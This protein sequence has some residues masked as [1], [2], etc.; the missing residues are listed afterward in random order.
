MKLFFLGLFLG[1]LLTSVL[2]WPWVTKLTIHYGDSGDYPLVGWMLWYNQHSIK[3]GDIFNQQN[4]FNSNQFYPFPYSLA[5][6]EHLFI[7]SLIFSPIFWLTKHFVFSVNFFAFLTFVLSFITSFYASYYFVKDKLAAFLG[8]A[9]YTFNP[10]TFSHFPGHLHLMNKYFLPLVFLF[11]YIFFK[12]PTLK[13]AFLFF[14]LFTLNGLSSIYFEAFTL[15]ALPLVFLP[16]LIQNL[17]RRN[18]NYFISIFKGSIVFLLF[19][20]FLLYFNI[21]YFEFSK[22]EGIKRSLNENAFYSAKL[23][24]WVLSTKDNLIYGSIAGFMEEERKSIEGKRD[25]SYAEHTLF[26]NIFPFLLFIIG[27]IYLLRLQ[28]KGKVNRNF[29]YGFLLVLGAGFI[30]TL[31][32]WYQISNTYNIKLPYFYFGKIIPI[33]DGLRVPARFQFLFYVPFTF[34][35][36]FG[37]YFIFQRFN[38][39]RIILFI[40]ILIGISLENYNIRSYGS[41][42]NILLKLDGFEKGN[43]TILKGKNTVHIPTNTKDLFNESMYLNWAIKTEENTLNGYSGYFPPEWL[44][45]IESINS[46]LDRKMLKDL[47]IIDLDYV[48]IH[49]N[50][51]L[52][53]QLDNYKKNLILYEKGRV[54]EDNELLI[55]DM[56]KYKFDFNRCS[57]SKNFETK[58]SS[59]P[60]IRSYPDS[61]YTLFPK[62]IL[63]NNSNC[64][65]VSKYNRRYTKMILNIAGQN[66]TFNIKLPLVIKP[67]EEVVFNRI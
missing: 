32:P 60:Q 54:F 21:P 62:I 22:L 38:K 65:L 27:L 58:L 43:L 46:S 17:I 28:K 26:L 63:K 67:Y 29:L 55:I 64:Y 33:L 19:L 34:F 30:F 56:S 49:K 7:P 2:T 31:G 42:S 12:N 1:L 18:L 50:L 9:V 53:S 39:L 23:I 59:I 48:I 40:V 13:N 6:S 3:K 47:S 8:A 5:F 66:I 37:A 57:L 36:S 61:T 24:D 52:T 45:M 25:F 20:P 14:L 44:G 4:Y 35:V 16:F 15:V 51:L 41:T 11:A 10:L